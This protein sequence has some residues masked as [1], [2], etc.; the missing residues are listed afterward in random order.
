MNILLIDDHGMFSE[1]LKLT[2]ERD[3][4]IEKVDI[5]QNMDKAKQKI[6]NKEY[7]IILMDI[8]IKKITGNEDGLTIA[9]ELLEKDNT[10]KIVMLTGFD[11]PGYEIEAQRIGT[12]GFICK[13][14]YTDVLI[15]KLVKVYNGETVFRRKDNEINELTER[16]REILILYSSGLSRKEVANECEISGSSLAVTLNRIYEKLDVKNYQEMINK[17]LEIGYIK[18]SFF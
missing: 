16:E 17:A 6:F 13:D 11:M 18:P 10:L 4:R 2:L 8:N 1:S 14:E 9:K 7:D 3:T 5:L 15:G 12:K